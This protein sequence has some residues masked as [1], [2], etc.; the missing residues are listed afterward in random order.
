MIKMYD[1]IRIYINRI[2]GYSV[3]RYNLSTPHDDP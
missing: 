3:D 2:S 1:F